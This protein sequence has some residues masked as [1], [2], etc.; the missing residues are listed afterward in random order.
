[1]LIRPRYTV[2]EIYW[3]ELERRYLKQEVSG[4]SNCPGC[5]YETSP[6]YLVCPACGIELRKKCPACGSY[7][8]MDWKYC[9]YCVA[10]VGILNNQVES[11]IEV[12]TSQVTANSLDSMTLLE[13]N[14]EPNQVEI[15]T[16]LV[17]NLTVPV[18]TEP[19]KKINKNPFTQFSQRFNQY[20]EHVKQEAKQNKERKAAEAAMKAQEKAAQKAAEQAQKEAEEEA[21]KAQAVIAEENLPVNEENNQNINKS[22]PKSKS[23]SK[24]KKK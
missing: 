9:P 24:K 13:P 1:L 12:P 17:E 8:E 3:A 5:K 7:N 6:N 2:D 19:E 10:S 4:L 18:E 15:G 20:V 16:S 22:N 23:K 14:L 11:M 21:K